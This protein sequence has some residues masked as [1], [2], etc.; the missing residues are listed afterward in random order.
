MKRPTHK[1]LSKKIK[2]AKKMVSEGHVRVLNRAAMVADALE[3]GYLFEDEFSEILSELID[4]TEPE[5][6]TGTKPPQKSYEIDILGLELFAFRVKS[7]ILDPVIYYKFCIKNNYCY[8][9][10]LHKDRG[11]I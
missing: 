3:L 2:T 9:I 10:S 6:Y 11:A 5:H 4:N 7:D 8:V 1:E